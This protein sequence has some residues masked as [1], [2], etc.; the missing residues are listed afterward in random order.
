RHF[1]FSPRLGT[2]PT[3]SNNTWGINI[4][5][6]SNSNTIQSN[7]ITD[8]LVDGIAIFSGAANIIKANRVDMNVNGIHVYAGSPDNT[9]TSN[10]ALNNGV[11]DLEDDSP[12]CDNN[13]W[14]HNRFNTANQPCIH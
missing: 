8:Q 5:Q 11:F 14:F 3:I 12:N 4:Q 7:T 6:V 13:T 1:L 9:I 10:V 2:P